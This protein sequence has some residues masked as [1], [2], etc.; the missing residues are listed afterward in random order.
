M[1]LA[2]LNRRSRLASIKQAD[3]QQS[4]NN[5]MEQASDESSR[6][7]MTAISQETGSMSKLESDAIILMGRKCILTASLVRDNIVVDA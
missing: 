5:G 7:A 2:L 1:H 6:E 4:R 3:S